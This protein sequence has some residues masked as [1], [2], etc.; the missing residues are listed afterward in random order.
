MSTPQTLLDI[1]REIKSIAQSG[2]AYAEN[3]FDQER[4]MRLRDLAGTLLSS[5][6]RYEDFQW[7]VELGYPTPK[8]DVRG[9]VLQGN[10]ILLV[11]EASTGAWT[12]PGGWADV[13]YTP[14]ENVEREVREETGYE[15]RAERIISLID[16]NRS[17]YPPHPDYIYKLFFLCTLCGGKAQTSIE[18]EAVG[19]FNVDSLPVLDRGRTNTRDIRRAVQA[20]GDSALPTYFEK[21]AS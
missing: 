17:D 14:A 9:V 3:A 10:E 2:L 8:L 7:P 21:S 12:L 5:E 20:H 16:R 18:T 15:V 4:Y 11:K 1:A 6:P 19:F 13:N